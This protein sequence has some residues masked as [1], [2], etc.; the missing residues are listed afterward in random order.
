MARTAS[1]PRGRLRPAPR[2]LARSPARPPASLYGQAPLVRPHAPPHCGALL[3]LG[4]ALRVLRKGIYTGRVAGSKDPS[5]TSRPAT[6]R[7]GAGL[8][9]CDSPG[10]LATHG[11]TG[12]S[13]RRIALTFDD[14]P[15]PRTTPRIL[16][17]LREH[18]LKATFFVLG[19]HVKE[20]PGLLRRIVKEGHTVGNH[21]YN[22]TDMS[23]LSQKRMR[24][25]LRR[26]QAAVDDALG[27]HYPMV[28]MRPPYGNPYLDGS[29]A[30]PVFRK[31]VHDQRLFPILRTVDPRDYMLGGRP[32]GVLQGIVRADE[33][34]RKGPGA[35][36]A[37]HPQANCERT[38]AHH[39]PLR[40]IRPTIR[41]RGRVAG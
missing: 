33:A 38:A 20:R 28:L 35:A 21:T 11:K 32:E 7:H 14:G 2:S 3:L 26:T 36:L 19:R 39:R 9:R 40:E 1:R 23:D 16:D 34:G 17:S 15:D 31:V 10:L 5:R 4:A 6:T 12:A 37:R 8:G 13:G 22:H 29:D 41:D 25:E 24:L 18:D 27:Y 30:L